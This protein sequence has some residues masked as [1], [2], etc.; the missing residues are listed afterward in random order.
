MK[1]TSLD[2]PVGRPRSVARQKSDAA[3]ARIHDGRVHGSIDR[4]ELPA[5]AT[6]LDVMILAM[7]VAYREG[8]AIAA[9]PYARDAAPYMHAR[10]AQMD[11]KLPGDDKPKSIQFRWADDPQVTFDMEPTAPTMDNTP[12]AKEA[13]K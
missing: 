3:A 8:G 4:K 7:R 1:T 11:L 12:T 9:Q 13:S 5:G 10:I 6:P 2:K